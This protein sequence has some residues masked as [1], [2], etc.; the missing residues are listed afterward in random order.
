MF[1]PSNRVR[2]A[3]GAMVLCS[4]FLKAQEN[5]PLE[6][7]CACPDGRQF[8]VGASM[9]GKNSA[10]VL[11]TGL[12]PNPPR[13][14]RGELRR[15][16]DV[17]VLGQA[18]RLLTAIDGRPY[19][20]RESLKR[21]TIRNVCRT[22]IHFITVQKSYDF[23]ADDGSAVTLTDQDVGRPSQPNSAQMAEPPDVGL[24]EDLTGKDLLQLLP[25]RGAFSDARPGDSPFDENDF[26]EG[27]YCIVRRRSKAA[28]VTDQGAAVAHSTGA[29]LTKDLSV[30]AGTL[31]RIEKR[32]GTRSE[33]LWVVE[34][35]PNSAPRPFWRSLRH[36]MGEPRA[37]MSNVLLGSSQI[38]EI[39]DF[40]DRY[41]VE[42]TRFGEA[43]TPRT[44]PDPETIR[45]PQIY[46]RPKLPLD[47]NLAA[48]YE[49]GSLDSIQAAALGLVLVPKDS[50]TLAR[51]DTLVLDESA[52]GSGRSIAPNLLHQQCFLGLDRLSDSE[53]Q[54]SEFSVSR[55][56][57]K[58]FQLGNSAQVPPGY[59][60]IDLHLLLQP[61]FSSGQ[62]PLVCRF[63]LGPI[64]VGL[65]DVAERILSSRFEIRRRQ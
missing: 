45:L 64:D 44:A 39:N 31:G 43:I 29:S 55:V 57:V 50:Q 63:P 10:R 3:I 41:G 25:R 62:V 54:P 20:K 9:Y 8:A 32:A 19:L 56:D 65:V 12:R 51:R 17:L 49:A 5:K 30:Y 37:L 2:L 22:D 4:P 24:S 53:R 42:W 38:A 7:V 11:I 33:P 34:L 26:K 18:V 14:A 40:L 47:E 21:G 27:A 52:A 13:G 1:A 23:F 15:C 58:T 61:N 16:T 60:A 59:Y 35:L 36:P 46:A 48:A 28:V 6:D